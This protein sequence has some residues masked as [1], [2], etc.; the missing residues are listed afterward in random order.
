MKNLLPYFTEQ[1]KLSFAH[2]ESTILRKNLWRVENSFTFVCG[3]EEDQ[4]SVTVPKGFLTD[5]ASV[6]RVFWFL[7]PPFGRYMDAAVAH[8]YLCEHCI[9]EKMGREIS[10]SRREADEIFF[11]IMSFHKVW[12]PSKFIL[13]GCVRLWGMINGRKGPHRDFE[14]ESLEQ[15]YY[16]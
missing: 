10:I 15:K 13:F 11:T 14:K 9:V 5:G 1:P 16:M 6:P 7:F 3:K 2:N 8:D 4:Y 12:L